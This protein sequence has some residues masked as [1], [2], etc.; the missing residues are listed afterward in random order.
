MANALGVKQ[1]GIYSPIKVQST[2]RWGPFDLKEDYSRLVTPDV[3]C[4]QTH[5]CA[6][7]ACPYFECMGKIEVE[8]VLQKALSL[9]GEND[10]E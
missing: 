5:V 10:T 1:V 4:G 6:G 2:L 8:E 3:G 9:L 7:E